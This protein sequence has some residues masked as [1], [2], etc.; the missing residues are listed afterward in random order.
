[1]KI[2]RLFL[3]CMSAIC[4]MA[5]GLAAISLLRALSD[6]R[7]A[8]RVSAALQADTL[9]YNLLEKIT[10]ERPPSADALMAPQP[11]ADAGRVRIMAARR[12][13]DEAF[14][15]AEAEIG[16]QSYARVGEQLTILTR[17]KSGLAAQ[18]ARVDEMAPRPLAAR[19]PAVFKLYL[20]TISALAQQ[21]DLALEMSD[22][23]AVHSNGVAMDL[24]ELARLSWLSRS[25][26]SGRTTVL[27][28]SISA[29]APLGPQQ[30]EAFARVE[31]QAMIPWASIDVVAGRLPERPG[32]QAIRQS[33]IASRTAHDGVVA[34]FARMV[35]AGRAGVAY[36]MTSIEF[37]NETL[38][39]GLAVLAIRDAALETAR[40]LAQ[41]TKEAAFN[42]LAM[43]AGGVALIVCATIA[44]VLMMTR[45]IVAPILRL[46]GQIERLAQR[47]YT[48]AVPGQ[49]RKDE[50]GSM[51]RALDALRLDAITAQRQAAEQEAERDLK[52]RR[53]TRLAELMKGFEATFAGM[54]GQITRASAALEGTAGT[55]SG[56]AAR[57][58]GQASQV[59]QAAGQANDSV[60]TVA[61]AAEE[62]AVSVGAIRD[63][64][65]RSSRMS[66]RAALDALHTDEIAQVLAEGAQRIGNV[67]GIISGIASQTNLLALNATIEAA[68]AGDAGKGFAVVASEVKSLS[69][70]TGQ[71][72]EEI[73]RQIAQMQQAT[74]SVVTA[75][76]SITATVKDLSDV[77]ATIAVAVDEQGA[78]TSEIARVILLTSRSVEQVAGTISGVSAA[79]LETDAAADQ[80]LSEAAELTRQATQLS[81]EVTRFVTD[82]NAA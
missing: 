56:T 7:Q 4:L 63:Q 35:A 71:A 51:A 53:T 18:R 9:L 21:I 27:L 69:R 66:E 32:L 64:V 30:L 33:I 82:V 78:A 76:R 17:A 25:L 68:R 12:A 62:L 10:S 11:I 79:A 59:A 58:G 52:E 20:S 42:R 46:T 80:V 48:L 43:T 70:Q 23:P 73:G 28:P 47:D 36:G 13:T 34:L 61:A 16:R 1:M 40:S 74:A 77:A 6:Y 3:V 19:D 50:L 41:E 49:D 24:L 14:T 37:G 81:G 8:S 45:R 22:S 5:G 44:A 57:T 54:V 67:V 55:M 26:V 60:Q 15:A 2:G 75:I 65:E 38:K 39:G 72:T 29:N 31:G